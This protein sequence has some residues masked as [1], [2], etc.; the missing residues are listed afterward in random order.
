[1]ADEPLLQVSASHPVADDA[2]WQLP[3]HGL[4]FQ[5]VILQLAQNSCI[6]PPCDGQSRCLATHCGSGSGFSAL[7]QFCIY[8]AIRILGSLSF[9]WIMTARQL[10]SVLISLIFF[11][12]GLSC[13]TKSK[14]I[15]SIG[16]NSAPGFCFKFT[17]LVGK[18]SKQAVT[19]KVN[20]SN[21]QVWM[22]FHV[23]LHQE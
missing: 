22:A 11:G 16:S 1:M 4:H 14:G 9:T 15:G 20:S 17:S 23:S 13:Q 6:H 12:P 18:R 2:G 21:L 10:L 19:N 8:S 5:Q 3:G 7:G